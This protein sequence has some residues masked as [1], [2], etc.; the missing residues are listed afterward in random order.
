MY[1]MYNNEPKNIFVIFEEAIFSSHYN[2]WVDGFA[3]IPGEAH[4]LVFC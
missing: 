1:N 2:F 3:S 4:A